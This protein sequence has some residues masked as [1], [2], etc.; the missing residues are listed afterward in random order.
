MTADLQGCGIVH[1]ASAEAASPSDCARRRV[2]ERNRRKAALGAEMSA[3]F[4]QEIP[5]PHRGGE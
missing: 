1:Q 5:P 2:S 4:P 3:R